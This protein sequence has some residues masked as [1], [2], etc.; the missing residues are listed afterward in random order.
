MQ[1]TCGGLGMTIL[2][3]GLIFLNPQVPA[4]LKSVAPGTGGGGC[5]ASY[6]LSMGFDGL[7]LD[8]PKDLLKSRM[9][10]NWFSSRRRK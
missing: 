3:P 4:Y 6:M 5:G 7:R 2:G 1:P 9:K 10:Q 8:A